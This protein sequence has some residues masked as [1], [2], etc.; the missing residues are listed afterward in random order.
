MV[1][2]DFGFINGLVALGPSGAPDSMKCQGDNSL[3]KIRQC[4]SNKGF[5]KRGKCKTDKLF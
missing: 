1:G 3:S 4:G 5:G 2:G